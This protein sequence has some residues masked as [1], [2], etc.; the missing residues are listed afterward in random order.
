MIFLMENAHAKNN[1]FMSL[2][3]CMAQRILF[4]IVFHMVCEDDTPTFIPHRHVGSPIHIYYLI[5]SPA[6]GL[7]VGTFGGG[8]YIGGP[9][10][11]NLMHPYCIFG[12]L[13]QD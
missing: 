7:E 9:W 4:R 5:I 2:F 3:L 12:V 10:T 13:A 8:A 1:H 11:L 6:N